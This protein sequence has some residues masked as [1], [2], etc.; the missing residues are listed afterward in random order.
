MVVFSTSKQV[1]KIYSVTNNNKIHIFWDNFYK[2]EK[3]NCFSFITFIK[4]QSDIINFF[5]TSLKD[6]YDYNYVSR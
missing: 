2:T 1:S 5:P 4:V 3:K 6:T